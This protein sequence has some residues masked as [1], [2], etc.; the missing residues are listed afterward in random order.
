[1]PHTRGT[2]ALPGGACLAGVLALATPAF[3][4]AFVPPPG[5][6]SVTVTYQNTLARGHL[7]P[8]GERAPGE[9]GRDPV[10]AHVLTW[11]LDIGLT[12]RIAASVS[13]PFVTSRY[14]G[15]NRHLLDVR[16]NP[17]TI[18]DGTYH[19][20][21]QDF[22]FGARIN[23]TTRPVVIT[24]FLTGIVPSHEYESRGHSVPGLNMRALE[25]GTNVAGFVDVLP[26]LY[27]HTQVS[28]AVVQKVA[29][30]R[31]NRSRIDSEIGYFL[32]PR[33]AVRFLEGFQITH[34]GVD[35]PYENLPRELSLNH[36]RLSRNNF[37]NL[38]VGAGFGISERLDL[39]VAGSKLVWGQNVHSH[40]GFVIGSNLYFRTGRGVQPS[41]SPSAAS[42]RAPRA[43]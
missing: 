43:H 14:G 7:L 18:D 41:S 4:Q 28:Y 31:P 25:A 1:M 30:I 21:L 22:R 16:G 38:G 20:A 10:Q 39:F 32:T 40:Q 23:V 34:D 17:T 2:G 6:G 12:D 27:F 42:R 36:D 24:P 29:G 9:A 35:F 33:L 15:A 13:L 37:L 5:E 8:S 3:P 19:S 26:G 11:D